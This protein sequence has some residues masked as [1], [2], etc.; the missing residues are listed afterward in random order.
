MSW[1]N[2]WQCTLVG[3]WWTLKHGERF[4]G[5]DMQEA[6]FH[7]NVQVVICKCARCGKSD[8]GWGSNLRQ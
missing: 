7:D 6:E 3:L 8:F 5:C 4:S 1:I 2:R